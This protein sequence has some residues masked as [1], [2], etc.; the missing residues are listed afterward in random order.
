MRF[1]MSNI[2]FS[3]VNRIDELAALRPHGIRAIEIAS[4]NKSS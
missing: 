4:R 3:P 2:A 1:G